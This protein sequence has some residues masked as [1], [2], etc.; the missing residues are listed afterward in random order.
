[1]CDQTMGWFMAASWI[2]QQHTFKKISI[3]FF[4]KKTILSIRL[5]NCLLLKASAEQKYA[6][7][8]PP[9]SS[10]C[11]LIGSVLDNPRKYFYN[12]ILMLCRITLEIYCILL[13]TPVYCCFF[14]RFNIVTGCF[15]FLVKEVSH[16]ISVSAGFVFH[17]LEIIL[18]IKLLKAPFFHQKWVCVIFDPCCSHVV[19]IRWINGDAFKDGNNWCLHCIR[20][21]YI[22]D[23][24]PGYIWSICCACSVNIAQMEW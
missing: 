14:S 6:G 5:Q 16:M 11:L 10:S 2:P 24:I 21:K 17:L 13:C 4:S 7:R 22:N 20:C 15:H 18:A 19:N 3:L 8:L 1:M 9:H 23:H 12:Y